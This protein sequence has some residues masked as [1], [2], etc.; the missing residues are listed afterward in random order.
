MKTRVAV[1]F[2][3]IAL[4]APVLWAQDEG[5][6]GTA[7]GA[8]TGSSEDEFFGTGDVEAPKGTAEKENAAQAIEKERVGLSGV[9]QA[10][11]TYNMTRNFVTGAAGAED[12]QFASVLQGDFLVDIRLL[13]GFRAFLDLGLGYLPNGIPTVHDFT[14]VSPTLGGGGTPGAHILMSENQTTLF[15][16]KEFFVDFNIN[17]VAYFRAG[18]Q[19]LKWGT[20]YFWNPT[21]LINIEHKS[22]TNQA[23]LLEGVV[24]LRSD[25]V[26][27]P[28]AH[29]Y[30]FLNLNGVQDLANVAF[31]ARQELLLGTFELGVSTWLKY[32]YLPVIGLDFTVGLPWS[33]NLTGEAAF[34]W[35]D[36]QPKLDTSGNPYDVRDQLVPKVDIGLSRTFDLFDVQN[37]LTVLA[38]FFYNGDGYDQD[39]FQVLS[40]PNLLKFVGG[41]YHAGY[42]GQ[43]YG[44]LFVSCNDFLVLNLTLSMDA[45][46]NFSDG[47]VIPMVQL[48]YAPVNNFSLTLQ[49][50]GYVGA[51]N[52]EYTIAV[53]PSTGTV[54]NNAL[55]VIL[56]AT[57]NF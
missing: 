7:V 27:S 2:L 41:Y 23:A 26:F 54:T 35:G 9:I 32:T 57:V 28:N 37:R 10:N 20:G 49:V 34:S 56:G 17:N 16:M 55:F 5:G 19:V 33:L 45:L 39:M 12:N 44:A 4:C 13:K 46:V 42:Y 50:G 48:S 52:T 11:S 1:L 14:L 40:T 47:S 51:D 43:Y 8:G 6:A 22:F 38:E 36:N 24:G 31:A 3:V 53:N 21:D 15:D 29:L 30:T 25:V 18:K